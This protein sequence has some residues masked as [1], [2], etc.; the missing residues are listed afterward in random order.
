MLIDGREVGA[1][2]ARTDGSVKVRMTVPD[3]DATGAVAVEVVGST[4][5]RLGTDRMRIRA[6]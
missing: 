5:D 3:V 4:P 1:G 2:L 6:R